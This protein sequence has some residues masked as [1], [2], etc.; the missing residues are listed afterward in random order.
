MTFDANVTLLSLLQM[1]QGYNET[2]LQKSLRVAEDTTLE[3]NLNQ[4]D[5]VRRHGPIALI[6]AAV[7]ALTRPYFL[8]D[9]TNYANQIFSAADHPGSPSSP[10]WESG[11]LLWRPIGWLLYKVFGPLLPA[12]LP[13]RLNIAVWLIGF[14]TLCAWITVLLFH[15]IALRLG[16]SR[17]VAAGLASTTVLQTKNTTERAAGKLL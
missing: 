17:W 12:A 8:A 9:T 11:H 16:A 1:A 14:S 13:L 6:S 15:S 5:W 3:Q 10:L 2:D 4:L 7:L